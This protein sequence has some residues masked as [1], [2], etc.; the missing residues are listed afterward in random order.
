MKPLYKGLILAGV[1]I[2]LVASLGGKY[3]YDRATRPRVWVKTRPGDRTMPIRG[4][5]VSLWLDAGM[6]MVPES[7]TAPDAREMRLRP[8]EPRFSLYPNEPVAFFIPE[9]VPD[10]SQRAAGEELWVEVT[11][12]KKGPPRPIR[13]GVKKGDTLTVLDLR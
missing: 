12:P 11:I 6:Q 3:L 8:A 13:L 9:R 4:R 10:P 7:G 1:Q 5:Y 2:A